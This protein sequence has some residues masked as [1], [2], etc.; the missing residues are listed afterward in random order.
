MND[1]ERARLHAAVRAGEELTRH[2]QA[3]RDGR[4][5]HKC[6]YALTLANGE[7]VNCI[8]PLGHEDSHVG[9]SD[10]GTWLTRIEWKFRPS[11]KP[12]AWLQ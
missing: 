4:E 3:L 2:L 10:D 7:N 12:E 1:H 6:D 8:L 9:E 11:M 5:Q